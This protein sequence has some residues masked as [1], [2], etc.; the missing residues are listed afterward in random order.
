MPELNAICPTLCHLDIYGE[1]KY[2]RFIICTAGNN[3]ARIRRALIHVYE[4]I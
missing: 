4:P 2:I 1:M 3:V